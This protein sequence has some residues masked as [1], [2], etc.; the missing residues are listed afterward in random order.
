LGGGHLLGLGEAMDLA[1]ALEKLPPQLEVIGIEGAD[2]ELGEGMSAA[3]TGAC[4]TVALQL[5]A[6]IDALLATMPF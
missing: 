2:F 5:A 3:V 6:R 1:Q 4:K